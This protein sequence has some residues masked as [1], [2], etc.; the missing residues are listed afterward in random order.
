M[1][2]TEDVG[3]LS[4]WASSPEQ[5]KARAK[6]Y[7][8]TD[9]FPNA[10]PALLST[11]EILD[12][13]R[14]TG[15]TGTIGRI[16][17]DHL[18]AASLEIFIGGRYVF[19]KD[20]KKIEKE[21]NKEDT[22]LRLPANSIVFVQ[23][24]N[25]FY[26]PEYIAM[27]FNLRI[28]HVHR[29]LLLGTGPLVDPGFRGRLLIPLHNLTSSDYLL[30]TKK[31]LIWAEFTKTSAHFERLSPNS[32]PLVTILKGERK[33]TPIEAYKNEVSPDEYLYKAGGGYPIASS[34]PT[35]IRSARR[36]A[37]RAKETTEKVQAWVR[38][39]GLLAVFG[40]VVGIAGI[41]NT[42][43]NLVQTASNAAASAEKGVARLEGKLDTGSTTGSRAADEARQASETATKL[44]RR[45]EAS[46]R[47]VEELRTR[48]ATSESSASSAATQLRALES[49]VD[50]L[51]SQVAASR[52]RPRPQS[53]V[54]KK[55]RQAGRAGR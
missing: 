6:R 29:G 32:T 41:V 53:R 13:D 7:K 37:R 52:N 54:R 27:R 10:P 4:L 2:P 26:L 15:M 30:D 16:D 40:A 1:D 18:K 51:S 43:W 55:R 33:V 31:A 35:A 19:W 12:Y 44:D 38:G 22:F 45:V 36:D 20:D 34:I 49:R 5:L 3:D 50:A 47:L 9:P 24:S 11:A 42:T 46:E 21:I 8:Q 14:V 17:G 28:T 25:V 48:L 23:T 39:F